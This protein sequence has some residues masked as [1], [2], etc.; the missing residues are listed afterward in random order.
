MPLAGRSGDV[1]EKI[2]AALEAGQTGARMGAWV[3]DSSDEVCVSVPVLL[4]A[5]K[6]DGFKGTRADVQE[7]CGQLGGQVKRLPAS[8]GKGVVR[9]ISRASLEARLEH[10]Y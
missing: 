5:L 4:Q 10:L 2:Q 8:Q 7:L 6:G 3:G 1:L 9:V